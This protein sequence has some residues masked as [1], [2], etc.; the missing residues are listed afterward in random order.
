MQSDVDVDASGVHFPEILHLN[1]G[2]TPYTT[3]LATVMGSQDSQTHS[4]MLCAMFSGRHSVPQD[5][6]GRY[7]ID[8]DGQHFHIVLDY[9]RH[10]Q[11]PRGS[12]VFV[13][14][15]EATYYQVPGLIR[16]CQEQPLWTARSLQ[17]SFAFMSSEDN[18][19][20]FTQALIQCAVNITEA[21]KRVRGRQLSPSEKWFCERP[22]LVGEKCLAHINVKLGMLSRSRTP[23][24]GDTPAS[25]SLCRA[26][27][28]GSFRGMARCVSIS[29]TYE[30]GNAAAMNLK[31]H[32]FSGLRDSSLDILVENTR[33]CSRETGPTTLD[34]LLACANR[35]T[36]SAGLFFLEAQPIHPGIH[37]PCMSC[38][39]FLEMSTVKVYLDLAKVA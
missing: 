26:R 33:P 16:W 12:D 5:S 19:A 25:P 29:A 2:G 3:R 1:V 22:R 21:G 20:Q 34:I 39:Y 8:R 14:Y 13:T 37:W 24:K 28:S 35:L 31:E 27:S 11:V 32:L 15:E 18:V 23:V 9:L 7:F 10:K 30:I 4:E 36:S 6:Q 17:D 38:P